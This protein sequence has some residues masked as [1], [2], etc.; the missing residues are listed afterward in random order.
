M[1]YILVCSLL[2]AL[3]LRTSFQDV[4]V[5]LT[6]SW[7]PQLLPSHGHSPWSLGRVCLLKKIHRI[8]LTVL[9]NLQSIAGKVLKTLK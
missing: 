5:D 9:A 1:F 4:H 7:Q 8:Q 3:T 2:I 6:L